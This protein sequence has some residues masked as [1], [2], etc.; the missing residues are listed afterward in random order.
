M[1]TPAV[2]IIDLNGDLG[3]IKR[4]LILIDQKSAGAGGS[5]LLLV[6]LCTFLRKQNFKT[7][8]H[9]LRELC[10]NNAPYIE[11]YFMVSGIVIAINLRKITTQNYPGIKSAWVFKIII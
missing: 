6:S 7:H 10:I 9:M 11:A 5:R 2:E 3:V 4:S 1:T 8:S